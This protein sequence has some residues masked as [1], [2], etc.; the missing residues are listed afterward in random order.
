M[1]AWA[2]PVRGV[3]EAQAN[4]DSESEAGWAGVAGPEPALRTLQPRKKGYD[5]A[6]CERTGRDKTGDSRTVGEIASPGVD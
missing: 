6:L 4:S 2:D 5:W 3:V 1:F